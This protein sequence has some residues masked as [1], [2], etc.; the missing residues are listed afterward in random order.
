MKMNETLTDGNS[1]CTETNK[2]RASAYFGAGVTTIESWLQQGIVVEHLDELDQ[3]DTTMPNDKMRGS[4]RYGGGLP[5]RDD[6]HE[7]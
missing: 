3:M 4:H 5:Q 6:H 7:S 1:D 2:L